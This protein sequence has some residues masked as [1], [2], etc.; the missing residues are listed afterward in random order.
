VKTED[1]RELAVVRPATT[2]DHL[3]IARVLRQLH[4][5]DADRAT[6]PRIR[7]EAQT[8][9]A[10]DGEGVVGVAVATLVDYGIGAYGSVEELVVDADHRGGGIGATLLDR[11]RAWLAASGAEVVFVSALDEDV[12][13]YYVAE[14]FVRCT[15]PWLYWVPDQDATQTCAGPEPARTAVDSSHQPTLP[16]PESH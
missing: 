13:S 4:P 8:F 6:L 12:A 7:Q 15:G 14:G 16:K 11:C 3:E 9:V 2:A 5:H 10:T 1:H